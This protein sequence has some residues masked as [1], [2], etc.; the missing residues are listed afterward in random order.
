MT[1]EIFITIAVILFGGASSFVLWR[2]R[3]GVNE[4]KVGKLDSRLKDVEDWKLE[5]GS[6]ILK[7]KNEIQK[8]VNLVDRRVDGVIREVDGVRHG[9]Q[10]QIVHHEATVSALDEVKDGLK[11]VNKNVL[12]MLQHR[13]DD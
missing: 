6:R 9:L 13:G 1:I 11:E 8:G 10:L 4:T 2:Y 5:S 12:L 7:C 3:S